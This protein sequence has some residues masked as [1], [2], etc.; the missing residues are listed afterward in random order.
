M[1]PPPGISIT[2]RSPGGTTAQTLW[3][4]LLARL[5]RQPPLCARAAAMPSACRILH[6]LEPCED[7]ERRILPAPIS[8]TCPS[9]PR[10]RPTPPES[11]RS[12]LRHIT[13]G[14]IASVASTG[15][16]R[17]PDGNGVAAQPVL[18]R[19]RT[20]AT[21][22]KAVHHERRARWRGRPRSAHA[23]RSDSGSTDS[24]SPPPA[25]VPAS[26]GP[27]SHTP[28]RA[29]CAPSPSAHRPQRDG[30]R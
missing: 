25:R 17:T 24:T 20:R 1:P 23:R 15:T 8:I 10:C 3:P 21:G 9:P 2:S 30:P 7:A 4:Q 19:P 13:N 11:C 29:A 18:F 12:S 16:L 6:P 26:P 27:D 5:Q 28:R 22:V 14:V